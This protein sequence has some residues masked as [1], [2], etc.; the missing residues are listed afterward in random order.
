MNK[1]K[2]FTI[3]EL[4]LAMTFLS[5]LLMA[6]TMLIM[7]TVAIYDKGISLRAVDKAGRTLASE[8]QRSFN[9]ADPSKVKVEIASAVPGAPQ[10]GRICTGTYSYVLNMPVNATQSARFMKFSDPS[11]TAC[12]SLPLALTGGVEMLPES[13]KTVTVRSISVVPGPDLEK[14]RIYKIA[15]QLTTGDDD[16]FADT[17]NQECKAEKN[18]GQYCATNR[19]E[20]TARA[21]MQGGKQ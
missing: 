7:Q 3:I 10:G 8:M 12:G 16:M 15:M 18:Y 13:D 4:L 2:G 20:F 6:I 14:Q 11:G 17:T 9:Q 19:F 21:S 5:I 1:Q